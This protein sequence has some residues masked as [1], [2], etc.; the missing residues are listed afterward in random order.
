MAT[1][2]LYDDSGDIVIQGGQPVIISGVE[3][4][5]QALRSLLSTPKGSFL[6]NEDMGL[7]MTFIV[8]GFDQELGIEAATEA[9]MQDK[10]V[11]EIHDITC[12]PDYDTGV[13][14]FTISLSSTVGDINFGK[15][16]PLNAAG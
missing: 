5:A 9:I 4:L 13:A 15:E 8:G 10:R 11:T 12:E 3:E 6:D 7:D 14:N 2:F 1:D 16:V